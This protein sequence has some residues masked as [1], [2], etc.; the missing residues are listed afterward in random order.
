MNLEELKN[1]LYEVLQDTH[2]VDNPNIS[3]KG[4]LVGNYTKET[5]LKFFPELCKYLGLDWG[6]EIHEL[7]IDK[8][9]DESN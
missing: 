4:F 1:E 7:S 5:Y 8:Y 6:R 2:L 9:K 3:F